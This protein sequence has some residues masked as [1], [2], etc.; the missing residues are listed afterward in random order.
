MILPY[1]VCLCPTYR[2]PRCLE[3]SIAC[4]LAQDYPLHRRELLIWDDAGQYAA[5]MPLPVNVRLVTTSRRFP[6]LPAKYNAMAQFAGECDAF[7]IWEDDDLY[8]PYHLAAHAAALRCGRWSKPSKILSLYPG[9]PV[10]E[11]SA[12]RFFA[13]LAVSAAL[14][15]EVR[16]LRDTKAAN[17]DQQFLELLRTAAGPPAD[18]LSPDYPLPGYCFR[19]GSTGAYHGQGF[20]QG[21]ADETWYDARGIT[22]GDT[23]HVRQLTPRFDADWQPVLDALRAAD[24]LHQ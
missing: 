22:G 18:T 24:T 3:N 7:V 23:P 13:S 15:R 12:G 19:W 2:R 4:W 1:L 20:M 6:S 10:L 16:G 8:L 5:D 11:G 17:F 21:P 14:W 9:R